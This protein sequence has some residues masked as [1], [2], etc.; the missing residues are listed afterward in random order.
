VNPDRSRRTLAMLLVLFVGLLVHV[1]LCPPGAFTVPSD[2]F[3]VAY[4]D[5]S[6][7]GPAHHRDDKPVIPPG[8]KLAKRSVASQ[9]GV[10]VGC[11][12]LLVLAH[13]VR[14]ERPSR[15]AV[16]TDPPSGAILLTRLCIS[17]T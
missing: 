2:T 17:R 9:A 6:G 1:L 13:V 12:V 16:W 8:A 4:A 7:G 14:P 11:L 3:A 10:L 5:G 15:N